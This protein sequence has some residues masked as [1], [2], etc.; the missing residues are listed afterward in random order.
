[1]TLKACLILPEAL[2]PTVLKHYSVAGRFASNSRVIHGHIQR[3]VVY[4]EAICDELS[5]AVG[6]VT[7][8]ATLVRRKLDRP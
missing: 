3:D 2:W 1:M 6:I 8:A 5:P 7:H 4:E